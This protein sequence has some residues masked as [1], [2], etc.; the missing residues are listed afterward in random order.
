MSKES[1]MIEKIK[2]F[3]E[4]HNHKLDWDIVNNANEMV[5]TAIIR[6]FEK[7]YDEQQ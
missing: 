3:S 5:L 6:L 2:Q 7:V 4:Q 1:L